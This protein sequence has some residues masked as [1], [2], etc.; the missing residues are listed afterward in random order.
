MLDG[1]AILLMKNGMSI[2]FNEGSQV[3]INDVPITNHIE[4]VTQVHNIEGEINIIS[5][6]DGFKYVYQFKKEHFNWAYSYSK[7][8]GE[9]NAD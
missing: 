7:L 3:I 9:E 1:K 5:I 4:L 8:V 6:V 2:D